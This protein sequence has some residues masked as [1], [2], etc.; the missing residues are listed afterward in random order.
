MPIV[1]VTGYP[2][3]IAADSITDYDVHPMVPGVAEVTQINIPAD[4]VTNAISAGDYFNLIAPAGA[5]YVFFEVDGSSG[6][7][8]APGGTGIQVDI[9]STDGQ[10]DVATKLAAALAAYPGSVV[11]N[12]TNVT[13]T[14]SEVGDV[15]DATTG[16]GLPT[17]SYTITTDG[18]DPTPGTDLGALTPGAYMVRIVG[19]YRVQKEIWQRGD[20]NYPQT[21]QDVG[22]TKPIDIIVNKSRVQEIKVG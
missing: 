1:K 20:A 22:E 15:A 12:G 17:W 6:N 16:V 2:Y 3:P 14:N 7:D 5:F 10:S 13:V 9:L 11:D 4:L 19:T 8:P 18:A 21:L